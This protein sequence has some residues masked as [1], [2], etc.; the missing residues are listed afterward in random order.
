[1]GNYM[2][3]EKLKIFMPVIEMQPVLLYRAK[4]VQITV[5]QYAAGRM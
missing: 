3:M 2:Y 4:R 5:T 1:M